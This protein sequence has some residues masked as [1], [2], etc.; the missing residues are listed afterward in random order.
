MKILKF[1]NNS[2]MMLVTST[3]IVKSPVTAGSVKDIT[4]D[5]NNDFS[6][7][8]FV[9][10]GEIAKGTSEI[11]KVNAAVTAGTTIQADTLIFSHNVGTPLYQIPYNQVKF[12]HADSLAGSKTLLGT[13]DID[14]DNEYT[15]LIDTAHT[16]GYLF[17]TLYNSVTSAG[18]G[19]SAGLDYAT[20]SYGSRIKIRE[21]V[22]SPH[23]WNK[24]LDEDTFNSLCDFAEA[25]IFSI[26][27]W[28]FREEIAS[29]STVVDQQSYTKS[30]AGATDLG[31]ILYA[32]Y[33]GRPLMPIS[34]RKN[35]QLNWGDNVQSG[36][37]RTILE[38][39]DSLKLT[40]TPSEVKTVKLY[41]YRNST[42]FTDESTVSE[43][44]LPQAIAFRVLQDLWATSDMKKSQYFERRYLQTI[45]AMKL[46]DIKQVS[47]FSAL[48]DV[49]LDNSD[50][51]FDQT[52]YP[53]RIT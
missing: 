23:N 48:S 14:A 10:A 41:Y 27:R 46:D 24:E 49:G 34:L 1:D 39:A 36:T 22:V 51:I 16:T 7:N 43:V 21:F 32:T 19:Y 6:Q 8:D 13:E 20:I 33:N 25:E 37:P 15:V 2:I 38:F 18:S 4:V 9:L 40:P 17:F 53:N 44:K 31:Q 11:F 45:S 28:R 26:K 30:E 35:R 52:L 50:N 42:G 5:N 3:A 12:Y 29:F 47:K